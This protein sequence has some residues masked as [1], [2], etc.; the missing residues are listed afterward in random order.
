MPNPESSPFDSIL[1]DVSETSTVQNLSQESF[2][3]TDYMDRLPFVH[4]PENRI[5][6]GVL[7]TLDP[8]P[9]D[10]S[11]FSELLS[12]SEESSPP[13]SEESSPP[14]SEES[15]P[16]VSEAQGRRFIWFEV[17]EEHIPTGERQVYPCVIHD[18][19]E[20]DRN[21]QVIASKLGSPLIKQR[22]FWSVRYS[23]TDEMSY[24]SEILQG[25]EVVLDD[26]AYKLH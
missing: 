11:E 24:L 16:P 26:F 9:V 21:L 4:G 18:R 8:P 7:T 2:E 17:V 5:I 14:V 25:N 19:Y 6:C 23:I 12:D 13:D 15:P 3:Y 1:A 20:F 10:L 22:I